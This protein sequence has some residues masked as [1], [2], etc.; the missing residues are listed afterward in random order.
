MTFGNSQTASRNDAV[1]AA[2]DFSPRSGAVGIGVR[3][4]ATLAPCQ[5]TFAGLSASSDD[6]GSQASL[7][8]RKLVRSR[9]PRTEVHGYYH[10]IATR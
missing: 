9:F 3:R 2:V 8:R 7:T 10:F 4:V 5:A 1:K 6:P